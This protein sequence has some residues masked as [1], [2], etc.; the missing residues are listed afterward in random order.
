MDV[1]PIELEDFRYYCQGEPIPKEIVD[2]IP[3][4]TISIVPQ[5]IAYKNNR[6]KYPKMTDAIFVV[7]HSK[8]LNGA[9]LDIQQELGHTDYIY[10]GRGQLY[11]V[12]LAELELI[13]SDNG[14]FYQTRLY[15]RKAKN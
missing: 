2:G 11:R 10:D 9:S 5:Q 14:E 8:N 15:C 7:Y 6:I 1:K 12:S 13:S 3:Y 4:T